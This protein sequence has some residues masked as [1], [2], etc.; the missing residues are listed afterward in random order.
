[1]PVKEPH[2][3]QTWERNAL[4]RTLAFLDNTGEQSFDLAEEVDG[5]GG[6]LRPEVLFA[7]GTAAHAILA[8]GLEALRD[9]VEYLF[10][11]EAERRAL[12]RVVGAATAAPPVEEEEEAFTEDPQSPHDG[13]KADGGS[14]PLEDAPPQL[15]QP[16]KKPR[17]AP[18][19]LP[20]D[21][22]WSRHLLRPKSL[23][24]FAESF[25][26]SFPLHLLYRLEEVMGVPPTN[27]SSLTDSPLVEQFFVDA[28]DRWMDALAEADRHRMILACGVQPAVLE[29]AV[30]RKAEMPYALTDF[31]ISVVFPTPEE[32]RGR[33]H[34][35]AG[36]AGT[37]T[38]ATAAEEEE[39]EEGPDKGGDGVTVQDWLLLAYQRNHEAIDV[40]EEDS[41]AATSDGQ[42]AEEG[43]E[44]RSA[45][46]PRRE[47]ED[48]LRGW[49]PE[50]EDED[51]VV[52]T[53]DNIDR[54]MREN[55]SVIPVTVLREKRKSWKSPSIT[56]FELE[57]HYQ[58]TELKAAVRELASLAGASADV[59]RAWEDA[60]VAETSTAAE[61]HAQSNEAAEGRRRHAHDC[62]VPGSLTHALLREAS[63]A[64]RKADLLRVLLRLHKSLDPSE[65]GRKGAA[66][67]GDDPP[68]RSEEATKGRPSIRDAT[69]SAAQ[70][71]KLFS[72]RELQ[73]HLERELDEGNPP[74]TKTKC[75]DA[76]VAKRGSAHS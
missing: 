45:P 74:S 4:F 69:L 19:V 54:Y 27:S 47:V 76:I 5:H 15:R 9:N 1:M 10:A 72:L 50:A 46:R 23:S 33:P 57:H 44:Q 11:D 37:G 64:T 16:R 25:C 26:G 60:A 49:N 20:H 59:V 52:L 61:G 8:A 51:E 71:V 34:G 28:F 62:Y 2:A 21:T 30:A 29:A 24:D 38:T 41:F 18:E 55:P 32:L 63:R 56:P 17:E 40:E 7:G 43:G 39:E 73:E 14:G 65:E 35:G 66:K 6:F 31:V 3:A 70:L 22:E 36:A 53:A 67:D 12:L 42:G 58:L 75:A 68:A 13:A 48:A